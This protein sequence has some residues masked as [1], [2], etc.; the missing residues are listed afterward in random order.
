MKRFLMVL[1]SLVAAVCIGVIIKH[2]SGYMLIAYKPWVL[3]MPLWLAGLLLLLSFVTFA[4]LIFGMQQ[5]ARFAQYLSHIGQRRLQSLAKDRTNRGFIAFAEG[6]WKEAEKLLIKGAE[7][8]E[9]PLLNY[10]IA[11]RAAQEL[12]DTQRRDAYLKKAHGATAGTDVAVGLTQ[13]QL[14]LHHGQLEQ[15]LATLNHLRHLAPRHPYVLKLLK[16]LYESIQDWPSLSALLPDLLKARVVT[17]EEG[18]VL[19][20]MINRAL[21][22]KAYEQGG[23]GFEAIEARWQGIPRAAQQD[24]QILLT[25]IRTLKRCGKESEA[26]HLLQQ[27]LK[28]DYKDALMQ[29]Y[30]LVSG[31]SLERQLSFAE[32]LLKEHA[33]N[34][35]ALLSL[36]RLALKNKLWGKAQRY[37]EACLQ[38]KP[39]PEAYAELGHLLERQG[40][41]QESADC[42]RKGLLL[43]CPVT[44]LPDSIMG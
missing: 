43:A 36:G 27:Q 35:H 32:G 15:S 34:P 38:I 33:S 2:D 7:H 9:T 44:G 22:A 12:G 41:I 30:G 20:V 5:T 18:Q 14:Q 21:L 24:E 42:F 39:L 26:E 25:H 37:L 13:A 8:S 10:L 6:H 3:E 17:Q 28:R 11:A 40:K 29:E 19:S 31:E 4:Y 1:I 16:N 23:E